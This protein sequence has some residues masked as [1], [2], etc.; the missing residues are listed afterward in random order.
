[1]V[2]ARR[3]G[4]PSVLHPDQG[5]VDHSGKQ[6]AARGQEHTGA[7]WEGR[8]GRGRGVA[9]GAGPLGV[10]GSL[11]A[12]RPGHRVRPRC[13]RPPINSFCRGFTQNSIRYVLQGTCDS[14]AS[15]EA[16]SAL[17]GTIQLAR[18]PVKPWQPL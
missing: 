6:P 5:R 18:L 13:T 16:V 7:Q 15:A 8:F 11:V 9:P 2:S 14:N 3:R 17:A 10:G 4:A 1:M 12:H